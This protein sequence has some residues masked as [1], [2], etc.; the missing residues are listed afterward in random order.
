MKRLRV[1]VGL[2]ALLSAI[3]R[4]E[5]PTP[6]T[7]ERVRHFS[8]KEVFDDQGGVIFC[9]D[10]RMAN[11]GKWRFAENG[12][13]GIPQADPDRTKSAMRAPV[14]VAPHLQVDLLQ[15]EARCTTSFVRVL[16]QRSS[17]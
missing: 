10:F 1:L 12:N 16:P 6:A 7:A 3:S 14:N 2:M 13:H 9:D 15:R 11:F 8:V 5:G 17:C 4:A